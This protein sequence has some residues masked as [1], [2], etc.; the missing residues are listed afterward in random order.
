MRQ[1]PNDKRSRGRGGR[2]GPNPRAQVFDSNGPG[3]RVR[4]NSVQIYEKYLQLARDASSSGDRVAAENLLQHA[5]HYYRLMSAFGPREGLDRDGNR[6]GGERG[7]DREGEGER[8]GDVDRF[9]SA[10]GEG[11]RFGGGEQYDGERQRD[12]RPRDERPRDERPRDDRPRD[13]RRGDDRQQRDRDDRPRDDRPRDRG[14][15]RNFE[16]LGGNGRGD[17]RND[18]RSE[19][20]GGADALPARYLPARDAGR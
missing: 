6:F 14:E 9:E 12:N 19:R 11:D 16:P 20:G 2:R 15:R 13:E 3:V 17:Y 7:E 4:G 1:N 18:Q 10:R 5:E 8:Y